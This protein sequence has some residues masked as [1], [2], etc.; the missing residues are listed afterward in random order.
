MTAFV[1][2]PRCAG[3]P[4]LKHWQ[5]LKSNHNKRHIA[6]GLVV[7]NKNDL[8]NFAAMHALPGT[9]EE[10]EATEM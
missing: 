9:L 10:V 6:K 1:C 8:M 3:V 7:K 5:N 2:M 4:E